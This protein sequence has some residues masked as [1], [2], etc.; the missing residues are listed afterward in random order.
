MNFGIYNDVS[1]EKESTLEKN[2]NIHTHT[3][4]GLPRLLSGKDA[5]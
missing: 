4:I 5:C 3:Y 1:K 2:P